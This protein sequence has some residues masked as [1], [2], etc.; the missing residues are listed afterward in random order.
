MLFLRWK[1][2]LKVL[3]LYNYKEI[4]KNSISRY[5]LDVIHDSWLVWV[6]IFQLKFLI[7][8]YLFSEMV[9]IS[10]FFKQHNLISLVASVRWH[11]NIDSGI[12][13]LMQFTKWNSFLLI[14]FA[15]VQFKNCSKIFLCGLTHTNAP[16]HKYQNIK[17]E[18][19]VKTVQ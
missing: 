19:A 17:N 8:L 6:Y 16:C 18:I 7:N 12:W 4:K 9:A 1:Q 2:A 5:I 10:L 3:Q 13:N 11:Q 15:I 14:L